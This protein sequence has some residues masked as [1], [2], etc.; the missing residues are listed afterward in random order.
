MKQYF[1]E[2][3]FVCFENIVGSACSCKDADINLNL[4]IVSP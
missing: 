2:F 1:V 3:L 4:R